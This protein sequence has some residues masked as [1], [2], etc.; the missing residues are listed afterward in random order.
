[1]MKFLFAVS[2][3]VTCRCLF[4]D[5]DISLHVISVEISH[6]VGYDLDGVA[7]HC[8]SASHVS[9]SWHIILVVE[10]FVVDEFVTVVSSV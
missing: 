8:E 6:E 9:E 7:F 5:S 1:M 10:I 3:D 4:I 2:S